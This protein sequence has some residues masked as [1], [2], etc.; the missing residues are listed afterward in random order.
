MIDK[1]GYNIVQKLINPITNTVIKEQLVYYRSHG[2]AG[3][4][5]LAPIVF[6]TIEDARKQLN[7]DPE[8]DSM[9][10]AYIEVKDDAITVYE[11]DENYSIT[12]EIIFRITIEEINSFKQR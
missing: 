8:K 5:F 10:L 3:Y 4:N 1:K 11:L 12:E 2:L 7:K 9:R 6:E